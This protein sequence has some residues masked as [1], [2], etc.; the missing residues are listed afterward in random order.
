MIFDISGAL[1]SSLAG[2][3]ERVHAAAAEISTDTHTL[4]DLTDLTGQTILNKSGLAGSDI[5]D[6]IAD[7]GVPAVGELSAVN[8]VEQII[9]AKER[10]LARK[11][12]HAQQQGNS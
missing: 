6:E 4:L 2:Y 7:A 3:L 9:S 12:A 8:K 11:R 1:P 10:Y 5:R